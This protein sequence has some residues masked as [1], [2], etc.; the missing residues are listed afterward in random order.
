MSESTYVVRVDFSE[1]DPKLEKLVSI[2]WWLKS[3]QKGHGDPSPGIVYTRKREHAY[4]FNEKEHADKAVEFLSAGRLK[5]DFT[6]PVLVVAIATGI[7]PVRPKEPKPK[8][9]VLV[10]KQAD[11]QQV[12][13]QPKP[14]AQFD[15]LMIDQKKK[16]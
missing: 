11:P 8:K 5:T 2:E 15:D 12:P 1:M 9:P 16:S 10:A 4:V 3:L 13:E 7:K 6:A 14:K